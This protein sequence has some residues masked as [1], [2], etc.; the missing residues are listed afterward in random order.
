MLA[1]R[2]ASHDGH[3]RNRYDTND[4][5]AEQLSAV[6]SRA[7]SAGMAIRLRNMTTG[8][9]V[10]AMDG[11]AASC[12]VKRAGNSVGRGRRR[13][14]ADDGRAWSGLVTLIGEHGSDGCEGYADNGQCD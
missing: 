6:P 13:V 7:V 11:L 8:V 12:G 1:S 14:V 5:P 10:R 9:L 3:E 2:A 4:A